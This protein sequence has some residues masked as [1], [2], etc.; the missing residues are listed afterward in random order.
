M[1]RGK[2]N[3]LQSLQAAV[4]E[5]KRL[6]DDQIFALKYLNDWHRGLVDDPDRHD[7]GTWLYFWRLLERRI[8]ATQNATRQAETQLFQ[9]CGL[10]PDNPTD[11]GYLLSALAATI[12]PGQVGA[13]QKWDDQQLYDLYKDIQI[14]QDRHDRRFND[15]EAARLLLDDKA[16]KYRV[17]RRGS[18]EKISPG[19]LRKRVARARD[20]QHSPALQLFLFDYIVRGDPAKEAA[21]AAIIPHQPPL[22]RGTDAAEQARLLEKELVDKARALFASLGL[23]MTDHSEFDCRI[24]ARRVARRTLWHSLQ[25]DKIAGH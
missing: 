16:R 8:K 22:P 4:V 6:R 11:R 17:N 19:S 18:T 21:C 12:Y 20:P 24:A 15:M 3:F 2:A 13:K 5:Q 23:V 7:L 1:S 9:D 25:M 14:L 10:N